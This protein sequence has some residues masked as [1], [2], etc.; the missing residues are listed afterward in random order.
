[1][2]K[3]FDSIGYGQN[4]EVR[5]GVWDDVITERK[6]YGDVVRNIRKSNEGEQLNNNINVQNT[7][8]IVA[9][10]YAYEHIFE[11]RYILWMGQYWIVTDVEV[12]RPRLQLR[13]GGVYNGPR[14]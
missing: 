4:K 6:Y 14:A 9:D 11:M 10:A 1:M 12:K 7:F 3:F 8:S 5:P 2:A 13:V